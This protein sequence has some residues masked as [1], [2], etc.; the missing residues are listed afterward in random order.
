M[1]RS[2][3]FPPAASG[4]SKSRFWP[5]ARSASMIASLDVP[6]LSTSCQKTSS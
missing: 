2:I 6:L 1:A 4:S 5:W 3:Y